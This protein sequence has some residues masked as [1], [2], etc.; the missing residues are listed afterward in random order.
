MCRLGEY[1]AARRH[2]ESTLDRMSASSPHFPDLYKKMLE[3]QTLASQAQAAAAGL[4]AA[5]ASGDKDKVTEAAAQV[6]AIRDQVGCWHAL[7]WGLASGARAAACGSQ[8]GT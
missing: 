4:V 6:T 7:S 8:P 1:D 2:L 3:V 5:R